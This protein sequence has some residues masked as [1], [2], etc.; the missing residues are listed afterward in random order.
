M[1]QRTVAMHRSYAP[2]PRSIG[3][4]HWGIGVMYR[5]IVAM[6]RYIGAIYRYIGAS[7]PSLGA[8]QGSRACPLRFIVAMH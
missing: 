1:Y 2:G 8:I 7:H 6:Y 3:A 5:L 4:M